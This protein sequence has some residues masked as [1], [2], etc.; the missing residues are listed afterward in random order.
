MKK[1]IEDA[2]NS[3]NSFF[4]YMSHYAVHAPW[5]YP[6]VRFIKNYPSL[7][8]QGLAFA[9]LVEGMDKSLG[10]IINYLDKNLF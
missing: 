4:A 9:T 10:D 6:D 8:G 5:Q 1:A 3:G 7:D 2:V